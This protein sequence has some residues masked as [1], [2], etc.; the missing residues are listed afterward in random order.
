MLNNFEI[1]DTI[2]IYQWF[3]RTVN[4]HS[5]NQQTSYKGY[6]KAVKSDSDVNVS[7]M[8]TIVCS[9]LKISFRDSKQVTKY[10]SYLREI[11][12]PK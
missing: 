6:D 8:K 12:M 5:H 3:D 1:R 10:G 4:V 11:I 9:G 7:I 2:S